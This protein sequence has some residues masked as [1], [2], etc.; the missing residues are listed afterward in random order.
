MMATKMTKDIFMSS[1]LLLAPI[2]IPSAAAWMT[3][4]RVVARER[5]LRGVGA[6]EPMR[7]A[8]SSSV[9]GEGEERSLR[10]TWWVVGAGGWRDSVACLGR[11]SMR[12]MSTK[13]KIRLMPISKEGNSECSSS[14]WS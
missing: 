8:F 4:P 1:V 2:A 14:S 6:S 11:R 3:K 10:E 7:P 9:G 5:A 12:N 13:P